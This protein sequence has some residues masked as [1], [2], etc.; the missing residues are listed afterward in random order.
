MAALTLLKHNS[1]HS[2]V[3]TLCR[4]RSTN[5][6]LNEVIKTRSQ[7]GEVVNKQQVTMS[8]TEMSLV[9]S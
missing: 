3:P 4:F 1:R 7:S 5:G 9:I 8:V 6:R 2:Q